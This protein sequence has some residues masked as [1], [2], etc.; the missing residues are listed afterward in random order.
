MASLAPSP[1]QVLTGRAAGASEEVEEEVLHII[2]EL[3]RVR[4]SGHQYH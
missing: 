4:A 1:R 2:Y 3:Q